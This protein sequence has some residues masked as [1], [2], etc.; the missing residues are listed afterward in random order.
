MEVKNEIYRYMKEL[1]AIPSISNSRE[2]QA[3]GEYIREELGRQPYFQAHPELTGMYGLEGDFLSRGTPYGLVKGSTSRTV[4]LTGHYDVV[5]TEEYGDF[6]S[7]AYD[8]EAWKL[9]QGK[10]L[11]TLMSMLPEEARAD[12]ETGEW[13]FGRGVNDMKGGLAVGMAL[14]DWYGR[15]MLEHPELPGCLLFAAVADEEAYSAG[16]RGSIPFCTGMQ[17][18]FGLE[19]G[20]LV[21]LEPSFNEDG[22]QQVYIG[23]VGKTMPAVLVQGVKAHVVDCFRGLNAIGVLAE[24]FLRTELAPEFSEQWEGEP[25]PPPTW[26]NLRDRKEG[27]DVSVP[28]RAAGYMSM[29]GFGKTADSVM[30]RLKEIGRE[31]FSSYM[32]RMEAREAAVR[33]GAVL[34]DVDLSCCVMEYG[35]LVRLCHERHGEE[36]GTWF[37]A[38]YEDAGERIRLGRWNYPRATLEIMD[39][40]LTYS[41]IT[42][43]VMVI[44]FAPPYYPAFHSDRLP[45]RTG[46]GSAFYGM[47]QKAAG[48][49]CGIRL[50]KR[51]YCCGISDLS[52]CAGPDMEEL[53]AYAAN[54][55][56]WGKVYGMNL[57]AMSV[58]QVPALLFGPVGRDAHQMSERV[59]ARSL[60]EEVPAILQHFI[61]QVFANDG[62]M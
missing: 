12:F 56:L 3:A 28:Y 11:E 13:L 59:N 18:R 2:E 51:N 62:G 40:A 44:A 7:Y 42:A 9:A 14:M 48:E 61:E 58:F 53:K 35:E 1:V 49:T 29:L 43:P 8:V 4:I 38:L 24:M 5:D 27:Y 41:G 10:E 22:R 60:L 36:A 39:A 17:G 20:C 55:P 57:D 16:M 33:S 34:P 52:Y 21:D 15:L 19:Y 47:L 25:C 50:G 32:E 6:Q 37:R 31:A 45:G 26:F 30:G 46:Q 23:S 54:A